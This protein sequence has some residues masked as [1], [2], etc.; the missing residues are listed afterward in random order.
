MRVN[1]GSPDAQPELSVSLRCQ[2]GTRRSGAHPQRSGLGADPSA[3]ADSGAEP[4][5][6]PSTS[7]CAHDAEAPSTRSGCPS[8]AC[9]RV[10]RS[11]SEHAKRG[12]SVKVGCL[13]HV[14][15]K[16]WR[17]KPNVLYLQLVHAEHVAVD[18]SDVHPPRLSDA[19]CNAVLDG[20]A[21]G[22]KA[23]ALLVG[24]LAAT[25]LCQRCCMVVLPCSRVTLSLIG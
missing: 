4:G 11:T 1:E 17:D 6:G 22:R 7:N 15:A 3:G 24:A 9:A 16:Q 10:T 5:A 8:A 21:Q 25:Q 2:Q 13:Y 14:R 23:R 19:C 18:G 20:L 12:G